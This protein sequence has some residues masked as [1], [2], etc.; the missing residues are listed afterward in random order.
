MLRGIGDRG[1]LPGAVAVAGGTGQVEGMT[2]D[3]ERGADIGEGGAVGAGQG[4]RRAPAFGDRGQ[5]VVQLVQ[6][7][8][9][10]CGLAA[11]AG[12]AG[13]GG[14]GYELPRGGGRT[15]G[16]GGPV[17]GSSSLRW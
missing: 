6:Q 8:R 4:C 11:G 12:L 15:G 10:V 3:R 5:D 17:G 9:I 7:P 2:Q 13:R 14:P 16:R 1:G